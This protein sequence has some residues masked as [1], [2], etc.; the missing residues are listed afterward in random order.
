MKFNYQL[1]RV[2][3][4]YYGR[5]LDSTSNSNS[6]TISTQ[7]SGSNVVFYQD[8]SQSHHRTTTSNTTSSNTNTT[9][10]TTTYLISAVLNRIQIIDLQSV[11]VR[12]L[13]I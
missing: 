10:S 6:N 4:S 12:T 3:G 11:E 13:P 8:S 7:W 2:C 5:P 1:R 9:N